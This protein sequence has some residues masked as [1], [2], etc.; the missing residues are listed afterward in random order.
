MS[1]LLLRISFSLATVAALLGAP[2]AMSGAVS[3][4]AGASVSPTSGT[5]VTT[6]SLSVRYSSSNGALAQSVSVA[7][8][9]RTLRMT[10][11]SGTASNGTWQ[12][13]ARLPAG[14]WI[15]TFSASTS[16][17]PKPTLVGPTVSVA[18]LSLATPSPAPLPTSGG[19]FP[20]TGITVNPTSTPAPQAPAPSATAAP[21]VRATVVTPTAA[22]VAP[23]S[24]P[25]AALRSASAS[26]AAVAPGA[27]APPAAPKATAAAVK[28]AAPSQ[29]AAI[30]TS[31]VAGSVRPGSSPDA[32]PAG[33]LPDDPHSPVW[34]FLSVG[35]L[36]VA[37]I[38]IG[39]TAWLL[40][41]RRR[42]EE[43]SPAPVRSHASRRPEPPLPRSA[44]AAAR[45]RIRLRPTADDDPILKGMN[46]PKASAPTPHMR[47]GEVSYGERGREPG[48][49]PRPRRGV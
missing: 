38:A 22:P 19:P 36:L 15:T 7:V 42:T 32:A 48:K 3:Q 37:S 29:A 35:L 4:L 17:G 47:A 34:I 9:G 46:L 5:T 21:T 26:V 6:F 28:A 2:S 14:A 13:S 25:P 40:L 11:V 45:R 16:K 44:V 1:A 8:A 31:S 33:I 39:G 20:T 30:A 27:S 23:A 41:A 43:E 12:A 10:R 24:S 49:R 18:L